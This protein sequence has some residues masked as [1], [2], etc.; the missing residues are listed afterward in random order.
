MTLTV[1]PIPGWQPQLLLTQ[2]STTGGYGICSVPNLA[3]AP[4]DTASTVNSPA[5][6]SNVQNPGVAIQPPNVGQ[7]IVVTKDSSGRT[8]T[9]YGQVAGVVVN[10]PG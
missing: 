6:P 8:L 5:A 7:P 2:D 1:T 10:N 9:V 3:N 4:A